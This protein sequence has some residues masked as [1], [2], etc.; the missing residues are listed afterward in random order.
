[1][2]AM[3]CPARRSESSL[4]PGVASGW[5]SGCPRRPSQ[6]PSIWRPG[7]GG[8]EGREIHRY[9]VS[10]ERAGRTTKEAVVNRSLG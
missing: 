6:A 2:M 8:Q 4:Q 9:I 7:S 1:M 10:G 5:N 3:C